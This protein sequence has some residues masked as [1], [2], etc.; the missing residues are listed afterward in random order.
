MVRCAREA[1]GRLICRDGRRE[2]HR[3]RHE[4][5]ERRMRFSLLVVLNIEILDKRSK[6]LSSVG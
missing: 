2:R 3:G 4:R 1:R 5:R 6:G